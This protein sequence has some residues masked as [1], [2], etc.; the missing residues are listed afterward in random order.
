MNLSNQE[1]ITI[2][3]LLFFI[4][5]GLGIILYK[6][7]VGDQPI[8]QISAQEQQSQ[9]ELIPQEEL[10]V[11]IHIAG[12][13]KHPG[14]YELKDKDRII[15]AINMAGG[16]TQDANIDII[17]LAAFIYDGQ[18]IIVPHIQPE[19][20]GQQVKDVNLIYQKTNYTNNPTDQSTNKININIADAVNLQTLPGIGP[21]LSER[22]VIYR[23]HNGFFKSIDCLKEVSGIGDK[24]YEGIKDL[25]CVH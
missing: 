19:I 16:E 8:E 20:P 15:D 10:P 3:V 11:I 9:N 7:Q 25:I 18:K 13:V 14:V 2:I 6:N 1:K 4:I 12:A 22:I 23:D 21:V 17:N 24:K 5:S